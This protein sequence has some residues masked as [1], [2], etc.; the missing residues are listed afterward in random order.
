[1]LVESTLA[2]PNLRTTESYVKD[3]SYKK[4]LQVVTS[5]RCKVSRQKIRATMTVLAVIICLLVCILPVWCRALYI[6]F[7]FKTKGMLPHIYPILEIS[8]HWLLFSHSSFNPCIYGLI[9]PQFQD[10][11]KRIIFFFRHDAVQTRRC[12]YG[13]SATA[14]EVQNRLSQKRASSL[15]SVD[16]SV[17]EKKASTVQP[18]NILHEISCSILRNN[19]TFLGL[20]FSKVDVKAVNRASHPGNTNL[21]DNLDSEQNFESTVATT[22][23]V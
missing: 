16:N 10:S 12:T 4:P 7:Y 8:L 6:L 20:K 21:S 19:T 5:L 9:N 23:Q 15:Y 2:F 13:D 17:K 11:F 3:V 1:M 18:E 14:M 22:T